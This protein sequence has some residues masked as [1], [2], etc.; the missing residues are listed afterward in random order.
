MTIIKHSSVVIGHHRFMKSPNE[1]HSIHLI[2]S[3]LNLTNC[4]SV[5]LSVSLSLFILKNTLLNT[6]TYTYIHTH[7]H[8]HLHTHIYHPRFGVKLR[9]SIRAVVVS[10]SEYSSGLERTL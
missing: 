9:Y 4:V 5:C 1:L 8:T 7:L 10:A 2:R 6:H 3:L